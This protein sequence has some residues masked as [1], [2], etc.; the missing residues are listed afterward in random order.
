MTP[1]YIVLLIISLLV[2]ALSA[3]AGDVSIYTKTGFIYFKEEVQGNDF[4]RE[5]G[6]TNEIGI[7]YKNSILGVDIMPS[8]GVWGALLE[9]K[10]IELDDEFPSALNQ[11]TAYYGIKT[12]LP[13]SRIFEVAPYLS[14]GPL[15]G[16]DMNFFVRTIGERWLVLSAK[17]GI[18]VVSY[19][20]EASAGVLYPFYTSDTNY[21]WPTEGF[22]VYPKAMVTT[23]ADVNY[24]I[25][26]RWDVGV[27][28]EMWRWSAS[29][30][31]AYRYNGNSINSAIAQ[32]GFAY[33]PDTQVIN[34]GI[35]VG[36]H[37]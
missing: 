11:T 19:N 30:K 1:A 31:V 23:F 26:K 22:T 7:R 32:G 33:Q 4:V 8:L 6:L 2:F 28:Y 16:I 24:K 13:V 34:L 36:Y 9:Y 17:S 3:E 25:N 14:I 37:F 35:S 21:G 12:S 15:V 27:Y 10:G 18:K 20:V 29:E 5:Q